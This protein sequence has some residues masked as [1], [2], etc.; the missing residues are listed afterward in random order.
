MED[1]NSVTNHSY[2]TCW[3]A[4]STGSFRSK[5]SYIKGGKCFPSCCNEAQVLQGICVPD[6]A[7][8]T[9]SPRKPI[10]DTARGFSPNV[11]AVVAVYCVFFFFFSLQIDKPKLWLSTLQQA[12]CQINLLALDLASCT[13]LLY[14][15]THTLSEAVCQV[16][17]SASIGFSQA[18]LLDGRLPELN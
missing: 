15:H 7:A 14:T 11:R 13:H 10:C 12:R 6:A 18:T 9:G 16:S 2:N 8:W 3:H 1:F 17:L 5:K 4:L